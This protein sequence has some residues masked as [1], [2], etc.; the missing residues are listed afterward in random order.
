LIHLAHSQHAPLKILAA[1]NMRFF[2]KD[3]PDL[4]EAAIDAIYDL[5]EDS[6]AKVHPLYPATHFFS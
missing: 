4:E 5:C 2:L 1:G 3:F 6:S